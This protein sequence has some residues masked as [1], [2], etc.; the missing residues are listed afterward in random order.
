MQAEEAM[1]YIDEGD[2]DAALGT[3]T[4]LVRSL[5]VA[6]TSLD[7]AAQMLMRARDGGGR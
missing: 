5:E 7:A 3:I 1:S 2:N 6:R 4:P